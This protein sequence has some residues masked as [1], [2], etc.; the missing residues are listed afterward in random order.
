MMRPVVP[1]LRIVFALCA[2]SAASSVGEVLDVGPDGDY[3]TIT[4]ALSDASAGDTVSVSPGIYLERFD[5]P[6]WIS[7]VSTSGPDSTVIDGQSV[8]RVV[9]FPG[10]TGTAFVGFTVRGGGGNYQ[11]G[12]IYARDADGMIRGNV[13]EDNSAAYGAGAFFERSEFVLEGNVFRRNDSSQYGGGIYLVSCPAG[14]VVERNMIYDNSANTGGGI[15][16][17][18]ND[19]STVRANTVFGNEGSL[20]GGIAIRLDAMASLSNNIIVGNTGYGIRLLTGGQVA[21]TECNDVWSNYPANYNFEE[22]T[23]TLGN[24]S[25][26]P[27]FCEPASYVLTLSGNSPCLPGQHPDGDACGLIGAAGAGCGTSF[28]ACCNSISCECEITT[29]EE[30]CTTQ[31]SQYQFLGP[32]TICDPDPC[33]G[34]GACCSPHGCVVVTCYECHILTGGA[35]FLGAGTT[36]SPEACA[37]SEVPPLTPAA[38]S[39]ALQVLPN[40]TAGDLTVEVALGRSDQCM[41]TVLDAHGRVVDEVFR[42]HLEAGLHS[43]PLG[44]L[45]SPS[46]VYFVRLTVGSDHRATKLT[47]VRR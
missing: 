7:I 11:G 38:D 25:V 9:R 30:E 12:G 36:C 17:N 35:G 10:T 22:P 20:G 18:G 3:S 43:I 37:T 14:M 41:L 5:V 19:R 34:V 26:D 31:G 16:M 32:W 33:G 4:A 42:G 44:S 2:V 28:G 40:P 27:L 24:I 13:I 39:F 45:E 6:S 21:S 47:V 1:I 29:S 23:G 15:C 8:W 46:G